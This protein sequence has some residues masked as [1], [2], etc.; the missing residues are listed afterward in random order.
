MR[1]TNSAREERI[2]RARG[3]AI[4]N[5][6]DR[7]RIELQG[8]GQHRAGA[9][10]KCG[11]DDRF[12]INTV[13]QVFR[14]PQCNEKGGDIIAMVMGLDDCDF[15]A[16]ITTLVGDP[17]Q[18]RSNGHDKGG[19]ARSRPTATWIYRDADDK[20]YLKVERFD[21]PNGKKSYP[22]WRWDGARWAKGKPTGPKI[23]YR[24]PELLDSDHSEP[25][26]LCE[27][28]KCADAVAGLGFAATSASEGA[29]KW[30]PRGGY[31]RI[32]LSLNIAMQ[33]CDGGF[34]DAVERSHRTS[35]EAARPPRPDERRASRQ[36]EQGGRGPEH[37]TVHHFQ[38]DRGPGTDDR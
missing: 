14:C 38:I 30:T 20:P 34:R 23:P 4:E 8:R 36:H 17:Q 31:A 18:Q 25:V 12:S 9:C 32:M 16:A 2:H 29:G 24:L 3:V 10:P 26:Y 28:E 33:E 7:R 11:G 21:E 27:G 37:D 5:E 1:A 22:Q 35:D 19:A 6:C 13:K 15:D